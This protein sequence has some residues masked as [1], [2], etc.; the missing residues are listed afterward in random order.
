M[1]KPYRLVAI[2]EGE[3]EQGDE[4]EPGAV[5]VLIRRWLRFRRL[6]RFFEIDNQAMRVPV[7]AIKNKRNDTLKLGI[8]RYNIEHYVNAAARF[9]DADAIIIII[10]ADDDCPK[11]L[12]PELLNRAK[13]VSP[14]IPIGIVMP[15]REYEAWFLAML[16][17]LRMVGRLNPR[18][19]SSAYPDRIEDKRDCKGEVAKLLVGGY[20]PTLNQAELSNYLPFTAAMKRRSRSYRKLLDTLERLAKETRGN[21]NRREEIS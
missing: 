9:R 5:A 14:N 6:D 2:V 18:A 1:T 11:N 17:K 19:W 21:P 4:N 20:R 3:G 12:G 13:A 7:N 16:P 10:D 8:E 15:K